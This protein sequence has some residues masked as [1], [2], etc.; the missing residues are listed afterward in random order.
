MRKRLRKK[1]TCE[2]CGVIHT[3]KPFD[4]NKVYNEAVN[5]LTKEVD[6]TILNDFL[7]TFGESS[8]EIRWSTLNNPNKW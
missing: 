8:T 7:Y 4:E 3:G 5:E 6:H 1:L 2:R